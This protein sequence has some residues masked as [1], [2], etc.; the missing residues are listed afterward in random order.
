VPNAPADARL[1]AA[2]TRIETVGPDVYVSFYVDAPLLMV[3]D[4]RDGEEET[5][6]EPRTWAAERINRFIARLDERTPVREGDTIE[7]A[8]KTERLHVFDPETGSAI[9]D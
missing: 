2:V 1:V 6:E 3:R 4:P 9:G 5:D 7:L 8:V